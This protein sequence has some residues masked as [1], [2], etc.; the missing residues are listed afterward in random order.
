MS[1]T[2]D[3]PMRFSWRKLSS[4][5][6]PSTADWMAFPDK[7][8]PL[9]AVSQMMAND[10]LGVR[11]SDIRH[12]VKTATGVMN[13]LK[14]TLARD[15]CEVIAIRDRRFYRGE[16]LLL[17]VSGI[18]IG[19]EEDEDEPMI[20]QIHNHHHHNQAEPV[21]ES[22]PLRRVVLKADVDLGNTLRC[23]N[24]DRTAFI[25]QIIVPRVLSVLA[26][27]LLDSGTRFNLWTSF[28]GLSLAFEPV[29]KD[30]GMRAIRSYFLYHLV[31]K[32]ATKAIHFT[33][34]SRLPSTTMPRLV[35]PQ[36]VTVPLTL[37]RLRPKLLSVGH[38]DDPKQ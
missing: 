26:S 28:T 29:S 22:G 7:I 11:R 31:K 38:P 19:P 3:A 5:V 25:A 16:M 18:V 2:A 21:V 10:W 35:I 37:E 24:S 14:H 9:S 33:W 6:R 15:D 1:N 23:T 4:N 20:D 27:E 30:D 17:C 32:G 36:P 12:L 13:I 8:S 34:A